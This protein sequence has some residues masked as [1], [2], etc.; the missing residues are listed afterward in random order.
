MLGRRKRSRSDQ[1]IPVENIIPKSTFPAIA[2]ISMMAI[3]F[4]SCKR[5]GN[6][7][8]ALPSEHVPVPY[9]EIH[10][11]TA[12]Y[13]LKGHIA[14]TLEAPELLDYSQYP[15]ARQ[16]FPAGMHMVIYGKGG[17]KTYIDA[18]RA[19]VYKP[20]ELVELVGHVRI[21]N[22]KHEELVTNRLFWDKTH[23][24]IFTDDSVRF[25]RNNEYIKGRG[26][27]SNMSFTSARVNN[28]S[29]IIR[30]NKKP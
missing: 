8:A 18:R 27:D 5:N 1:L 4:F 19:A 6:A 12:H 2:L 26:F 30:I 24:H 22:D 29:G 28:I 17:E 16:L 9:A 15:F 10:D 13:T 23:D 21:H 14:M 11:F 3:A 7:R 20:V 25:S